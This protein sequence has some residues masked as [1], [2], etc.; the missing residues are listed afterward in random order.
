[1]RRTGKEEERNSQVRV[2]KN[3]HGT[4]HGTAEAI[5]RRNRSP[6]GEKIQRNDH[7][8]RQEDGLYSASGREAQFLQEVL[9]NIR[10]VC[11]NKT[12]AGSS[13]DYM[14]QLRGRTQAPLCSDRKLRF[15]HRMKCATGRQPQFHD[16]GKR[17][18]Y[19]AMR[20]HAATFGCASRV[21][22][23]VPTLQYPVI[24]E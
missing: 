3:C 19:W 17:A 12:Q 6:T 2:E 15:P 8:D 4:N 24:I 13:S 14:P 7:I 11:G 18:C 23:P 1:M 9:F 16:Q 10:V 5:C 22:V 20:Y 21:S